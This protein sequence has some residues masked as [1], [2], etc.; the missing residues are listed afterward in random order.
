MKKLMTT[1]AAALMFTAIAQI[2]SASAGDQICGTWA[3]GGAFQNYNNA[4][5]QANKIGANVL[6]LDRSNSPNAGKGYWVV[7]KGP[8]SR[9]Y[10]R[11]VA[12]NWRSWGV[13]GAYAANRCFIGV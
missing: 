10:A 8:Y 2:P 3:F 1:A 7:A 9:S 11:S 12:R 5:R 6:D 13:R 4:I